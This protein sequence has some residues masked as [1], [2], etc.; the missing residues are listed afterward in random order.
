MKKRVITPLIICGG[1]ILTS[2]LAFIPIN[3]VFKSN[4][5]NWMSNVDDQKEIRTLSIPGTHDSGATH[6][7]GDVAGKCQDLSIKEQLDIGVRFFDLRLQM[8]NDEFRICHD[9]LDQKLSFK[10]VLN[11]LNNFID[12][13]ETEFLL[14]SIKKD[15]DTVNSQ[16]GFTELF[17]EYIAPYEN[18]VLDNEVPQYVKD[19]RGKIYII[20]RYGMDI[21]VPATGWHDNTVFETDDLYVQDYYCINEVEDKIQK[22]EETL[23]YSRQNKDKLTINFASCYIDGGFPPS[24]AGT[25]AVKINKHLKELFKIDASRSG[26]VLIDYI[27]SELTSLI[28]GGNK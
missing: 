1:I 14:I 12:K 28:I 5:T 4:L 13:Y 18:I 15:Y 6:S 2:L 11:D 23:S 27:G 19:A 26:I 8:V 20:D 9:F 24:Y 17:K 25:P 10:S 3:G 16:K 7:I 22:I 21:G